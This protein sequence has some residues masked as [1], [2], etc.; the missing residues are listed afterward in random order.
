VS[1]EQNKEIV[2]RA[3]EELFK[4]GNLDVADELYAA[5]YV[6]HDPTEP[7]EMRGPEG[8]KRYASEVRDAFPDVR[9]TVEDQ[10]AEGEE[11]ATRYTLVGTHRG[12]LMGIPPTGN[13]VEIVGVAI[14]RLANGKI[15]ESW[16][17]YDA[18]G[19]MQQLGV[20]PAPDQ[21]EARPAEL[22]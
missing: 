1:T 11:V 10:V 4:L 2:R 7:E 20:I 21:S 19:M 14:D 17:N 15:V 5:G 3:I 8:I 16:D 13:P 18:L 9:V 22:S 6:G 12:E